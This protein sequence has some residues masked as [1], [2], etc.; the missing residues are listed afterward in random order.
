MEEEKEE[1]RDWA[2][3]ERQKKEFYLGWPWKKRGERDQGRSALLKDWVNIE[4]WRKGLG[5][6]WV[7]EEGSG[8]RERD[9]KGLN[10]E[11]KGK[12]GREIEME[13]I[14]GEFQGHSLVI[15]SEE[16]VRKEKLRVFLEVQSEIG[17]V[18]SWYSGKGT[19][20]LK[21]QFHFSPWWVRELPNLY[22]G[23]QNFTF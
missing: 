18:K 6:E 21:G 15:Q 14:S 19:R 16:V 22:R 4:R 10:N 11:I 13:E 17:R 23:L 5:S 7:S 12:K 1:E 3:C 9:R 2:R 20:W 8:R